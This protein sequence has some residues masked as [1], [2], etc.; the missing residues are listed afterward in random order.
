M[1]GR[2]IRVT[3]ADVLRGGPEPVAEEVARAACDARNMWSLVAHILFL[4]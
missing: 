3:E 4:P 2:R 1:F